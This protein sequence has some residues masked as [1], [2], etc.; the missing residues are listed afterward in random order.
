MKKILLVFGTRPEAI[1]M[2]PVVK[3]FQKD[4]VNFDT[5]VCVTGQHREMLDQVLEIFDIKPEY[6][7]NIMK[8]GQDLYDVTSRVV[9][10]MRDVLS[11][12]K[13]DIVFVH[14]DTTTSSMTALAAYYQQIPVAHVEAGLRTH[15]IYSP[16]PEEINR[17][18]TGRIATYNF[19]P[20]SL[21]KENLLKENI[22]EDSIYVTGNTVI[23]ALQIVSEKLD[24]DKS[25]KA[26]I[27]TTLDAEFKNEINIE[28]DKF[29]LITGHSRE[30]FGQGFL[31]ICEAIGEIANKYPDVHLIYPVHLNP[32]VQKPVYELLGEYKN[33][34][35]IEPQQYLPFVYLMSKSYIV[36][37][38]SGGIQE[39]A[40]GLGKPVLVMR[41]T[42]ERPEAMDAGTVRLVGT[43]KDLIVKEVTE[44][45]DNKDAY[46]KM[47]KAHNPY[48]DGKASEKIIKALID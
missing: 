48:G 21:S 41:D 29:L 23:D 18:M 43:D 33:V 37:T 7:L 8:A 24:S 38:D 46:Q 30:N 20:T 47:S 26:E 12:F 17:Q 45:I 32:N 16:W 1:K 35:L 40:P 13:P 25:L 10:G 28:S 9:L 27:Q 2:A 36:L 19:A 42:T 11:E 31:N 44:L 3:E 15:N 4:K 22:E 14:G 5:K 39:E 34:H 6:D